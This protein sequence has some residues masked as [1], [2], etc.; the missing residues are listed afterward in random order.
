MKYRVYIIAVHT[1]SGHVPGAVT[2]GTP[3]PQ[4][5]ESAS[6][7]VETNEVVDGYPEALLLLDNESDSGAGGGV[8]D[9]IVSANITLEPDR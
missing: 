6:V 5:T 9:F 2:I 8:R 7:V 4:A 1:I 3:G